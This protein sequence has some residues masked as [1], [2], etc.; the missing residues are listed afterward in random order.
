MPSVIGDYQ[1]AENTMF[2]QGL[3]QTSL[4]QK[5]RLGTIRR[6]DDGREYIYCS[7]TAAQLAAGILISK[8]AAPQDCTV[9]A[10]DV[11]F[12]GAVG[13]K[14]V[15]VTLTGTP[16][17][18]LYQDG[19]MVITAGDGIGEMYKIRGNSADDKPAS[20]RCTFHL[21]E[22]LRTLWVA[23]ST[24][25][26]VFTNPCAS[27]LINP[28]VANAAATTQETVIGAT[29]MIVP[30]SSYFWAQRK[31]PGAL[32]LD[33]DAAAGGEA[34]EMWIIQGTTAGRGLVLADTMTPGMQIIAHTYESADLT[35]AEANFVNFCIL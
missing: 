16:T 5:Q 32:I 15:S 31:G 17:A 1:D 14:T 12:G 7:N 8:A 6:L 3:F 29:T 25:I 19:Y 10:A 34:N 35:D 24:T 26:S 30:A 13:S 21:Y 22:A 20:G 23:A 27:L 33:V 11:T 2:V 28:A 4:T 9:A 18:N